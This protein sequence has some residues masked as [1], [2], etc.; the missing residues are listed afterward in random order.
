MGLGNALT[1]H[2]CST[3]GSTVYWESEGFLDTSP[4]PSAT[5]PNR[6]S[7]HQ[8]SRCGRSRVTPGSPY[9]PTRRPSAWRSRGD[10]T[11]GCLLPGVDLLC[12]TAG[13]GR[14]Q[15]ED[16]SIALKV[17]RLPKPL[18]ASIAWTGFEARLEVR[19]FCC[20]GAGCS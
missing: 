14:C 3:C 19:L 11:T 13:N 7:P 8:P 10:K 20:A 2:F 6:I 16:I 15:T 12:V 18:V 17:A 5:S 4:L 9:R 1:F